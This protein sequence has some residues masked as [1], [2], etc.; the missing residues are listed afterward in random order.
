MMRSFMFFL[1]CSGL[2]LVSGLAGC[3]D[4]R[5]SG[6]ELPIPRTDGGGDANADPRCP[7]P[8]FI[9][10]DITCGAEMPDVVCPG[11]CGQTLN[12]IVGVGLSAC[13]CVDRGN[14]FGGQWTCDTTAC[15]MPM[16]DASTDGSVPD[17]GIPDA[18][19]DASV[20][21]AMVDAGPICAPVRFNR[22][23]TPGCTTA[24]R[25]DILAILTQADFD[26]FMNNPNNADCSACLSSW[27]L[28]CGTE[29]GC[30]DEAGEVLCCLEDTCGMDATCQSMALDG[31][32]LPQANRLT[33]C[34][35]AVPFCGLDTMNPPSECFP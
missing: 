8:N 29:N 13:S 14:G 21:D 33:G 28:A 17:A 2:V 9:V 16:P 12:G 30:D 31:T 15:D 34:V 27:S 11:S 35:N 24:Q 19:V 10:P 22:P 4:S 23:M 7:A 3:D 26:A 25:G 5:R 18:S 6:T 32:C 20:P 1:G